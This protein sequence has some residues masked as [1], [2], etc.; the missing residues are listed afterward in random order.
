MWF[1]R[2]LNLALL[3]AW[4]VENLFVLSAI[5]ATDNIFTFWLLFVAAVGLM[6][7]TEIWYLLKKKR[8]LFYLFLNLLNWIGFIILLSLDNKSMKVVNA[9]NSTG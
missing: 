5:Y 8:S 7:I 2:H 9:S 3:F 4:I 6:L 1:S